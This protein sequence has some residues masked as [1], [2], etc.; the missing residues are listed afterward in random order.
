VGETFFLEALRQFSALTLTQKK[1][2]SGMPQTSLPQVKST[3]FFFSAGLAKGKRTLRCE[4][5]SLKKK[6]VDLTCGR[7]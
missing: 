2:R 6:L 4:P 1:L 3:A 7:C 5:A